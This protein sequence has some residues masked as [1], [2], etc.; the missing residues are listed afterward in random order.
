[1]EAAENV[2]TVFRS[3]EANE[4]AQQLALMA[5]SFIELV[6]LSGAEID[7]IFEGEQ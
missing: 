7:V 5:E 4:S 2:A 1:M 6:G 3:Q